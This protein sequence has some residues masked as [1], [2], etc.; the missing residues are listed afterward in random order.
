MGTPNYWLGR[1]TANNHIVLITYTT[2]ATGTGAATVTVG[3]GTVSFG[4]VNTDTVAIVAAG[5]AALLQASTVPE[6]AQLDWTY[7]G[8]GGVITGTMRTAGVPAEVSAATTA[9]TGITVAV[10]DSTTPTGPNFI[11]AAGN[12]SLGLPVVGQDVIIK[13]NAPD[14][15]YGFAASGW[16]GTPNVITQAGWTG[17]FGLPLYNESAQGTYLEYRQRYFTLPGVDNVVGIGN[18]EGP[19]L[20]FCS[21]TTGGKL[22]VFN[23]A[24]LSNGEA[25]VKIIPITGETPELVEVFGGSVGIGWGE[26]V[27]DT[28]TTLDELVVNGAAASVITG[29]DLTITDTTLTAGELESHSTHTNDITMRDGTWTQKEGVVNG[30]IGSGGVVNLDHEQLTPT[31]TVQMQPACGDDVPYIDCSRVHLFKE[32]E[33]GHFKGGSY[34]IDPNGSCKFTTV[35]FDKPSAVASSIGTGYTISVNPL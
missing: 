19:G 23:A 14:L 26:A 27:G 8:S 7:P 5:V 18:G 11:N 16:T 30:I 10:T 35:F 21:L 33:N 15:L 9:A 3:S 24:S 12:F 32:F 17:N 31:I 25:A 1:V 29:R 28:G 22:R 20:F 34:V 2:T 6:I 4:Y 13:G